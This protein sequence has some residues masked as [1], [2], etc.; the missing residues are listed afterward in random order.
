MKAAFNGKKEI[1]SENF[2]INCLRFWTKTIQRSKSRKSIAEALP[3]EGAFVERVAEITWKSDESTLTFYLWL[4]ITVCLFLYV[5]NAIMLQLSFLNKPVI[6]TCL[7][8][9][10]WRTGF[11][12]NLDRFLLKSFFR[13]VFQTR[14][15]KGLKNRKQVLWQGFKQNRVFPALSKNLSEITFSVF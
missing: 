4:K 10:G 12:L 9:K 1:I 6:G 7:Q 11:S 15:H 14:R 5:Q 2:I 8:I 13:A 3:T